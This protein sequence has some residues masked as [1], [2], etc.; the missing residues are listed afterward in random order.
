ME[1]IESLFDQIWQKRPS[2]ISPM[3]S[4]T[5]A[6]D[7]MASLRQQTGITVNYMASRLGVLPSKLPYLETRGNF[8]P[9]QLERLAELAEEFCLDQMAHLFRRR[10]SQLEHPI[11]EFGTR[12]RKGKMLEGQ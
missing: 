4:G 10:R 7:L 2:D 6:Q 11:E 1:L 3:D 5:P 9:D 12:R 8:R